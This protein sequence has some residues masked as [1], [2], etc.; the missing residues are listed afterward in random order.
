[1]TYL[2]VYFK[3]KVAALKRGLDEQLVKA[4]YE[5]VILIIIK[6]SAFTN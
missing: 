2:F 3:A 1:M 5:L 6:N 4:W